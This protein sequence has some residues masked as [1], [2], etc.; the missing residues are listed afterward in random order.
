M[1]SL[2][3]GP[4]DACFAFISC[5]ISIFPADNVR[6]SAGKMT[7]CIKLLDENILTDF[8]EEH[9]NVCHIFRNILELE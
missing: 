7:A 9:S 5:E 3:K 4:S 6:V 2:K 8:T 1:Y